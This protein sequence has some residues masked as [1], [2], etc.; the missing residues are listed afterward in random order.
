MALALVGKQLGE[1]QLDPYVVQ[2]LRAD[3]EMQLGALKN[4][5]YTSGFVSAQQAV[6][7][8]ATGRWA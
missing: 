3:V 7:A 1:L 4:A 5:A 6:V 8:Q 2:R